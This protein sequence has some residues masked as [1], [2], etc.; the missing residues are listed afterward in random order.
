MTRSR[1][2]TRQAKL[3]QPPAD[4]VLMHPHRKPPLHL[5]P[6][7]HTSPTH[8]AVDLWIG[9]FDH[10]VEQLGSLQLAQSRSPARV[11]TRLQA[12]DAGGIVAMHPVAQGLPVHAVELCR[13]RARASFQNHRHGQY[14]P[15]LRSIRAPV[16]QPAQVRARMLRSGNLQGRAHPISP[17]SESA[18]RIRVPQ[19]WEAP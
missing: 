4:R 11:A 13:F 18:H 5:G 2:Q 12:P 19:P 3:M 17:L 10:Q 14:P 16:A 6:Q 9:A 8:H 1:L 7:I 15:Y